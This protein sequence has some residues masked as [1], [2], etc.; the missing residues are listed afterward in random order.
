[1]D[2]SDNLGQC[3]F[4][5]D[6]ALDKFFATGQTWWYSSAGT[7]H[8]I[9]TEQFPTKRVSD[10]TF[11]DVNYDGKCDVVSEGMYSS[12]GTGSWRVILGGIQW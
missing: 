1:M 9:Y 12:G 11:R 6:G 5:G 7:N 2:E 10:V 4:N 8:W 3:D